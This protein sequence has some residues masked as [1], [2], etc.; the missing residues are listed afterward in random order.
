MPGLDPQVAMHR[1]NIKPDT[2]PV[3]QQQRRFRPDIMEAIEAEVHKLI[4]CDFIWEEQHP[5]WVAN[6]VPILKKNEKNMNL[7]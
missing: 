5:D 2:K 7:Y 3:K 6:I 4:T 1:L